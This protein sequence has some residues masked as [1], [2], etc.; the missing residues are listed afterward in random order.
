METDTARL[1]LLSDPSEL[2]RHVIGALSSRCGPESFFQEEELT[3][4]G[5]VS[6]VLLLL[7]E[8]V[9]KKG[10]PPEICIILNK[11]SKEVKQ[12][13]DLCCP[14]GAVEPV[15]DQRFARLLALP[16]SPLSKWSC[17]NELR[18]KNPCEARWLAI[19]LTAGIRESW[20]EMRLNPFGLRFLGPV[21]SQRLILFRRVVHPMVVWVRRQKNYT[22]SWEVEKVVQIPLRD[23]LNPYRYAVHRLYVPPGMEWRFQG[24]TMDYPCFLHIHDGRAELLW[25]VTF[26]IVTVFLRIAFGFIAPDVSNLPLVPARLHEEYVNGRNNGAHVR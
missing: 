7:G 13:G 10:A 2:Q 22:L 8:L 26:R 12:P 16:G 17:W 24:K 4:D 21:P 25:G 23:L 6:S 1:K 11:R 20:E 15:S 14:G 5:G 18:R 19:I 9:T 3:L